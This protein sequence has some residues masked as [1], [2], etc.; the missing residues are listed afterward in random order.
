MAALDS[1]LHDSRVP[2]RHP[3]WVERFDREPDADHARI[4]A[5][6]VLLRDAFDVRWM[7]ELPPDEASREGERHRARL[8]LARSLAADAGRRRPAAWQC[9]MIAGGA[10]FVE[11][12]TTRDPRLYAGLSDWE[13]PLLTAERLSPGQS[14]P[15]RYLAA[16]YLST[17][18]AL[19]VQQRRDAAELIRSLFA[20]DLTEID[21]LIDTWVAVA[22]SF[23]DVVATM[24]AHPDAWR[25]LERTLARRGDV[26]HVAWTRDRWRQAL[27]QQ[28]AGLLASAMAHR[29]AGDTAGSRSLLMEAI[30]MAPA[31][32]RYADVLVRAL[33]ACPPGPASAPAA[34]SLALWRAWA[35]DFLPLNACPIDGATLD[36]IDGLVNDGDLPAGALVAL[37]AGD[38]AR[39]AML[40]RRAENLYGEAWARYNV[41][42]ANRRM[43]AKDWAAAASALSRVDPSWRNRLALGLAQARL[44]RGEGRSPDVDEAPRESFGGDEFSISKTAARMEIPSGNAD[45]FAVTF[46]AVA[47]NEA[48]VDIALDGRVLATR[49]AHPGESLRFDVPMGPAPHV[50]DVR[51]TD[52]AMAL[53]DLLSLTRDRRRNPVPAL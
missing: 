35:L 25:R 30:S 46:G 41:V 5:A 38:G 34:H 8:D 39:A 4:N 42:E 22:A 12:Y 48:L 18:F 13:G 52:G 24:P 37:E 43:D 51:F 21:P 14:E 7:A 3:E 15:S 2:A 53:P 47:R 33:G 16:A 29:G 11:R 27:D 19:S 50:V 26:A 49:V 44:A 32:G 23:E 1:L 17:W 10:T 45:G 6:R 31:D 20:S 36:R 9:P 28:L 40:A